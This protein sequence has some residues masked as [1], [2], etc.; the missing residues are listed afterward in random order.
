[1]E[2]KQSTHKDKKYMVYYNGKWIHFGQ[3]GMAQYKDSTL[4]KLY[5]Y[6]DHNDEKRRQNYLKRAKGITDKQG[7]LTYK[8]K[9]SSN[10]WSINFLW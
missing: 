5:S 1:M 9:N 4:L 3:R 8:D 2:F 7:N 10:Y 6:L